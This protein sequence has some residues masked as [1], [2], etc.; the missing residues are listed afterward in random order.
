MPIR[1]RT[2]LHEKRRAPRVGPEFYSVAANPAKTSHGSAGHYPLS[3]TGSGYDATLEIS[4]GSSA[5]NCLTRRV[6]D[7]D[8]REGATIMTAL[9]YRDAVELDYAPRCGYRVS[10]SLGTP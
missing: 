7:T 4:Y 6:H 3:T 8:D 10:N 1:I 9:R 2:Q 5:R